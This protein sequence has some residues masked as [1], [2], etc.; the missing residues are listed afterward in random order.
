[1]KSTG[2]DMY[3]PMGDLAWDTMHRDLLHIYRTRNAPDYS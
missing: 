1:M 3:L 2:G